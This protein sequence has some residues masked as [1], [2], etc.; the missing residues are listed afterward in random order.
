MERDQKRY[1]LDNA[2]RVPPDEMARRLGIPERKVRRFLK[3]RPSPPPRAGRDNPII[4]AVIIILACAIVYANSLEGAFI[5]D[6]VHLV[7]N[8]TY[9]KSWR[10]L[11]SVFTKD[12]A[13]GAKVRAYSYRPL[14]TVS[15]MVDRSLWGMDVTGYHVTNLFFHIMTALCVFWL[16]EVL[17]R[18]RALSLITA[19]LFAVHPVHVEAVSYISGRADPMSGVFIL[20]ALILYIRSG[21]S[22]GITLLLL[23][24]ASYL[25]AV[26]TRENSLVVPFIILLYHYAFRVKLDPKRFVP[27]LA[28]TFA[29]ILFRLSALG[30]LF[31]HLEYPSTFAERIPGFFASISSYARLLIVPLGLHMD[32]GR[33]MFDLYDPAV[34]LG[35]VILVLSFVYII[36]SGRSG[37]LEFF[38]LSWFFITLLPQSNLYP[39]NAYMAEHWLYLPSV[40]F[41]LLLA[42]GLMKLYADPKLRAAGVIAA[43]SLFVFFSA[44]TVKQNTYWRDPMSFYGRV[45][46]FSPHSA[47]A[48]N[49][50]GLRY[51]EAG[52]RKEAMNSYKRAIES[53]PAFVYPYHNMGRLLSEAGRKEE[54]VEWYKKALRIDP[55]FAGTHYNLGNTYSDMNRYE[56]AVASYKEAL[57]I[58]PDYADALHNM[59]RAYNSMGRTDEA[60]R[61]YGMALKVNPTDASAY[62]NLGNIY[63]LSGRYGEAEEAYMKAIEL[64]PA[65]PDAYN[66]LG[67]LYSY[68]GNDKKALAMFKKAL[69]ADPD[70]GVTYNNIAVIYMRN[71]EYGLAIEYCD[72]AAAL[73]EPDAPLIEALKPH[74]GGEGR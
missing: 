65:G 13:A 9:V 5:W 3:T 11:P 61:Y 22:G 63:N 4:P 30:H 29:Y 56:E 67:A 20:L 50:L 68:K 44:V 8:N 35:I 10:Y 41:F 17:F 25:C 18:K 62:N 42:A 66:N 51:E 60:I 58:Y 7:K 2:G 74:R 72:R 15:Y 46:E 55:T 12:I 19:L 34:L 39:I 36:R 57:A 70:Y 47:R 14:Q 37:G 26:L 69:G 1:I 21:R 49:S 32:R 64:D 59:A 45:L 54:A 40:G 28:V 43:L 27:V 16:I 48:H 33:G 38:G 23:S 71:G 31:P 24:A 6:D 53:D 73:G 52:D